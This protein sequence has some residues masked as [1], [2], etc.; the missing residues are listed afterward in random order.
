MTRLS[1][2]TVAATPRRKGTLLITQALSEAAKE[3]QADVCVTSM[4]TVSRIL[5]VATPQVSFRMRRNMSAR[6]RRGPRPSS[7]LAISEP[8]VPTWHA[9]LN[10]S[11]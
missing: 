11:T 1:Q 2:S 9:D 6:P 7:K 3:F 5:K 10:V 4:D 8:G